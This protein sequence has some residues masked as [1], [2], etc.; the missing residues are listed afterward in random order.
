MDRLARIVV[1][2]CVAFLAALA[3]IA[4][5]APAHAS[6]DRPTTRSDLAR[7]FVERAVLADVTPRHR[8]AVSGWGPSECAGDLGGVGYH[9]RRRICYL[10]ALEV[11]G[12]TGRNSAYPVFEPHELVT[13]AQAATV[14][15]RLATQERVTMPAHAAVFID[16]HRGSVHEP[17]IRWG[18]Y[19]GLIAGFDTT[20]ATFRPDDPVTIRQARTLAA[21][22][23]GYW[24]AGG[25]R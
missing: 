24:R 20:P 19:H 14:V 21:R 12:D 6:P 9:Q 17:A 25:S 23:V 16:V 15:R 2:G 22:V 7:I 4:A 18:A 3:V 8:S 1:T 13:R 11:M 10:M 5:A